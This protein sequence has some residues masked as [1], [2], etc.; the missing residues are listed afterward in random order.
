MS[1][2]EGL[3]AALGRDDGTGWGL[4]LGVTAGTRPSPDVLWGGHCA[5]HCGAA[6][7]SPVRPALLAAPWPSGFLPPQSR[8]LFGQAPGRIVMWQLQPAAGAWQGLADEPRPPPCSLPPQGDTQPWRGLERGDGCRIWGVLVPGGC[9]AQPGAAASP[10][11]CPVAGGPQLV[12]GSERG[13]AVCPAVLAGGGARGSAVGV[14]GSR[15]GGSRQRWGI[16][17]GSHL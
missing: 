5:G 8:R 17:G 4:G 10:S 7:G 13:A 14:S 15:A 6:L 11:P 2:P 3:G 9:G 1:I 16:P 12:W